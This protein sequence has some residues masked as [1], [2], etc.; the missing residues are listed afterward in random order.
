MDRQL[1]DLIAE[2]V[3]LRRF[4]GHLNAA[5]PAI[6]AWSAAQHLD[7]ILK[8]N[9]AISE[10][11]R[12]ESTGDSAAQPTRLITYVVLLTRRIPRGRGKSPNNLMPAPEIPPGLPAELDAQITGLT[13]EAEPLAEALTRPGRFNHPVF[14]GLNRRQWLRFMTI[15]TRHHRLIMADLVD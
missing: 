14:G 15:H 8:V 10:K 11:I 2:L 4:I 7:H 1:T 9:A 3:A 12:S 13:A 6:T 5:R